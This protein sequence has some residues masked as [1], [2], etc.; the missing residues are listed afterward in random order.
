MNVTIEYFAVF[1]VTLILKHQI[2][3]NLKISLYLA[4]LDSYDKFIVIFFDLIVVLLCKIAILS[5]VFIS[6]FVLMLLMNN[7]VFCF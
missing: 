4:D 1:Q 3:N 6:Y 7:N 2:Y 5:L